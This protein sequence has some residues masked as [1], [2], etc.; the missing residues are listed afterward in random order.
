M[1]LYN[2]LG[3]LYPGRTLVQMCREILGNW[4]GTVVS[5]LFFSYSFIL[6]SLVLRNLGDFLTSTVLPETPIKA[7]HL[8]YL[9]IVIIGV[10]YGINNIA[11]TADIFFRLIFILFFIFALLLTPD[12]DWKHIQPALG[13][14]NMPVLSA[15]IPYIGFPFCELVLFLLI[16]PKVRIPKQA[17]YAFLKGTL[18]GGI[19]LFVI[20]LLSILVLGGEN[21]ASYMYSSFELAKKIKI[22][23]AIQRVEVILAAI[24]L[25]TIFLKLTLCFYFTAACLSQT[26][27]L[28][29]YRVLT[30]P[31]VLILFA[32]SIIIVPN[33]SFLISFDTLVWPFY[34]LTYG[35]LIPLLL[36]VV[37][38]MRRGKSGED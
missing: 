12:F 15:T 33:I 16:Y 26:L 21:T 27:N 38:L 18:L 30:L 4:L 35:L 28:S 37:A 9:V 25:M 20:T 1:L 24:W 8:L 11:R 31:L 5:L 17:G 10:H 32:L 6:T 7:I 22:G 29:E 3:S 23:E 19:V 13:K 34:A 36:L 2:V 14:G